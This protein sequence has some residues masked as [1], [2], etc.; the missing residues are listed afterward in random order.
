MV[1]ITGEEIGRGAEGALAEQQR[2]STGTRPLAGPQLGGAVRVQHLIPPRVAIH[3]A[4]MIGSFRRGWAYVVLGKTLASGGGV[5]K[6][7]ER[8]HLLPNVHLATEK[9]KAPTSHDAG[10]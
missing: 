3:I 5:D 8:P 2:L 4:V 9:E 7:V 6:K 10:L 1:A